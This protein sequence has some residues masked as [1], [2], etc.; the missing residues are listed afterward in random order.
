M[1]R[2]SRPPIKLIPVMFM[3]MFQSRPGCRG[4]RDWRDLRHSRARSRRFSPDR[5]ADAIATAGHCHKVGKTEGVSVPTGMQR[6]SRRAVARMAPEGGPMRR[7]AS[8]IP[9]ISFKK[10]FPGVLKRVYTQFSR[11]AR[12]CEARWA[13]CLLLRARVLND[14]GAPMLA[15]LHELI[16][17]VLVPLLAPR[18]NPATRATARA[19]S[20]PPCP[21]CPYHTTASLSQH[22]L[23]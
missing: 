10:R 8:M 21:A 23:A 4:R 22:C 18:L 16:T 1:Q 3:L 13:H 20:T 15:T 14:S 11:F 19:H 7:F 17:G 5:D 9:K 2:P 12:A 6:P